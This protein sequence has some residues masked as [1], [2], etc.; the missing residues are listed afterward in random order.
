VHNLKGINFDVILKCNLT[1]P[2]I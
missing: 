2:R 1:K